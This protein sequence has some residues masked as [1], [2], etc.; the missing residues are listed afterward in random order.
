MTA[1]PSLSITFPTYAGISKINDIAML[2]NVLSNTIVTGD[3]MIVDGLVTAGDGDGG[4]FVY[5]ATSLAVD[6]GETCIAPVDVGALAGRWLK[7]ET[8]LDTTAPDASAIVYGN[9]GFATIREAL[10]SLLY[11]APVVSAFT[12]SPAVAELGSTVGVV[13]LAWTLNKS[14]TSQAIAGLSALTTDERTVSPIGAFTSDQSWTLT[15]SDGQTNVSATAT[16][17]FAVHLLTTC[18]PVTIL[19]LCFPCIECRSCLLSRRG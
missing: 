14:V 13:A 15:A 5:D 11:V 12:A 1:S 10:D 4:I 3:N 19:A 17:P 8:S 16:R 2:R 9:Y 7:V 6:D 18:R